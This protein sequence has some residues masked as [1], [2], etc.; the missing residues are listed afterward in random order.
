MEKGL[1]RFNCDRNYSVP[2]WER[3]RMNRKEEDCPHLVQSSGN[4]LKKDCPLLV[5]GWLGRSG[6]FLKEG[7]CPHFVGPLRSIRPG[8]KR[9][10]S[11]SGWLA[12]GWGGRFQKKKE[13]PDGEGHKAFQLRSE[14]QCPQLG[15]AKDEPKGRR[16]SPSRS[17]LRQRA[18]KKTVPCWLSGGSVDP[19]AF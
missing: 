7:D 19:A 8:G 18:K 4:G 9:R 10:L 17:V 14:L 6:S 12:R 3:R 15:E 2:N 1:R 11:P 5:V 13:V 16:L